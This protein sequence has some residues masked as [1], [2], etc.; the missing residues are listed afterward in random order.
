MKKTVL[1]FLLLAALLYILPLGLR[2][3]FSPDE[4]RYAEIGR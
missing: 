2:E 4:T 3:M 1:C